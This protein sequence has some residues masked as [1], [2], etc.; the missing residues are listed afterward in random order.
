MIRNL[1]FEGGGARAISYA[2]AIWELEN[3][4]DLTE[5]K[6]IAG[7]SGGAVPAALL[8]IG[9]GVSEFTQILM[10]MDLASFKK[11]LPLAVRIYNLLRYKG[12]YSTKHFEAWLKEQIKAKGYNPE[13]TFAELFWNTDIELHILATNP[14]KQSIVVFSPSTTPNY[15]ISRAVVHSMTIP[16]VFQ[17]SYNLDDNCLLSDGG[18]AANYPIQIF[19]SLGQKNSQTLGF[20]LDSTAE[21][22][23]IQGN[24]AVEQDCNKLLDFLLAHGNMMH[25]RLN[26][27]H[28]TAEDWNRTIYIDTLEYSSYNF[29]LSENDIAQL[30][31]CGIQGVRN[32]FNWKKSLENGSKI[33]V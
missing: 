31:E 15:S 22:Q 4:I 29:N 7:T 20:R 11:E 14:K 32:Y 33:A 13:I 5:I 16:V 9:V 26:K 24:T 17:P 10:N 23:A 12:I 27:I 30:Y 21:I 25:D 1:V 3:Y 19:D 18:L 6:R 28:L 8:A 2:G